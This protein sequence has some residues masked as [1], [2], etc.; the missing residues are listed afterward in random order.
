LDCL[1]ET[2]NL[3]EK[4]GFFRQ[5]ARALQQPVRGAPLFRH[6]EIVVEIDRPAAVR[7]IVELSLAHRFTNGAFSDFF[8]SHDHLAVRVSLFTYIVIDPGGK[9]IDA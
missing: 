6:L 1:F 7:Q 8:E 5:D 4:C 3:L 9:F 2:F